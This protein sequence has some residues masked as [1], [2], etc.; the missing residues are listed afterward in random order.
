MIDEKIYQG[1]YD[2]LDKYLV[3]GW[4]K[5]VVYLEYGK[6]SYTFSFYVKLKGEYIKCYDIA[7]VSEDELAESFKKI[8]KV[9]EQERINDNELWSNMTFIVDN[10]GTMNADID[11][12]D[13]S[14]GTYQFMK[15]W[16]AKYLV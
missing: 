3:S 14:D 13:L 16:K 10:K 11:Y 6:A 2:E 8:D 15:K 7:G 12:T 9:L 5:L 1:I 4:E